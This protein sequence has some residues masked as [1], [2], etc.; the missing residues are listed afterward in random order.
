MPTFTPKKVPKKPFSSEDILSLFCYK[1]PQYTY[2]EAQKLPFT[3][4]LK[5]LKAAKKEDARFMHELTEIVAAP[6][7][8]KGEGVKKMLEYYKEVIKS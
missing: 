5:M 1:F 3:R 8:K 4:I 2:L 6:H 7:T